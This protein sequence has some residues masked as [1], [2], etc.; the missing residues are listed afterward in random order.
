MDPADAGSAMPGGES[1][2][3]AGGEL[4]APPE[5]AVGQPVLPLVDQ[6]LV[7]NVQLLPPSPAALV[8]EKLGLNRREHDFRVV[9]A[10]AGDS[11]GALVQKWCGSTG[12]YLEQAR[13]LNE[14]LTTLRVGQEIVLPWVADEILLTALESRGA[15]APAMA[16][17][18]DATKAEPAV[19]DRSVPA[20]GEPMHAGIGSLVK[21][22]PAATNARKY[23]IKAGESLWKIA[24]REVGRNLVPQFLTQVRELNP[25]LEADRI[26]EGQEIA[27]PAKN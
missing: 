24:E 17:A 11:L 21:P 22:A 23:K 18:S 5:G 8:T 27:L 6:P 16:S 1:K 13:G 12:D 4:K 10:R 14:E 19:A 15:A 3:A 7:A 2:S 9:R 26:R 25:G 20:A